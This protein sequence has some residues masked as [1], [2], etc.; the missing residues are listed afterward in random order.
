[1]LAPPEVEL[2]P[3]ELELVLPELALVPELDIVPPELEFE[4][5]ELELPEPEVDAVPLELELE[6]PELGPATPELDA[7]P[8][9]PAL[10]LP[11]LALVPPVLPPPVPEPAPAPELP[12]VAPGAP[13]D[14]SLEPLE[15]PPAATTARTPAAARD[16]SRGMETTERERRVPGFASFMGEPYYV[17]TSCPFLTNDGRRRVQWDG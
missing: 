4:P 17:H 5:P 11:E 13:G 2:A 8:L 6:P 10:T 1:M 9:E 14:V 3:P 12:F 7:V 16:P 15:Q